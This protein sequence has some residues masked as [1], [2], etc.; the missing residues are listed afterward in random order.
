MLDISKIQDHQGFTQDFLTHYLASGF[1][2]MQKRDL[3]TLVFG[4]LLKY[5]V[6]GGSADAPDATEISFQLGIS[7]ARVRN[8]CATRSCVITT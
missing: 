7:P 3:D 5:G 8:L 1:G 2:E 6:F 4:V